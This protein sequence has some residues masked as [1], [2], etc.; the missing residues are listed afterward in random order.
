MSGL[1]EAEFSLRL[2]SQG[3]SDSQEEDGIWSLCAAAGQRGLLD[4]GRTQAAGKH[5]CQSGPVG[6][7]GT[8]RPGGANGVVLIREDKCGTVVYS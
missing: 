4:L 2:L 6:D 3:G 5:E 7:V 8:E 1:L